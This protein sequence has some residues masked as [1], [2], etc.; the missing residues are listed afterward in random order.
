MSKKVFLGRVINSGYHFHYFDLCDICEKRPPN[1][2]ETNQV[3]NISETRVTCNE[4]HAEYAEQPE[5]TSSPDNDSEFELYDEIPSENEDV[6]PLERPSWMQDFIE[7]GKESGAIETVGGSEEASSNIEI[8]G[9]L[10][11][12]PPEEE[13]SSADIVSD[14]VSHNDLTL[15]TW[16]GAFVKEALFGQDP[17]NWLEGQQAFDEENI[18]STILTLSKLSE[19]QVTNVKITAI[20]CLNS[21]VR[22]QPQTK[23][24]VIE[25]L[26]SFIDDIDEMVVNYAN[27]TINSLK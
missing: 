19:N 24:K 3:N 18:E 2:L 4:C 11:E 22:R 7:E 20:H 16:S 27:E 17:E 1:W 23:S 12:S 10:D 6:T 5:V 8:L 15:A 26:N 21:V 13:F 9:D 25:S 14:Q